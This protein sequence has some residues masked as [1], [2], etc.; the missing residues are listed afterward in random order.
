MSRANKLS[1]LRA[2]AL[3]QRIMRELLPEIERGEQKRTLVARDGFYRMA[4]LTERVTIALFVLSA[5]LAMFVFS[6]VSRHVVLLNRNLEQGVQER[7]AE[8]EMSLSSL[9]ESEDR[10]ALATRGANDGLWDWDLEEKRFY[11]SARWK[12]MLGLADEDIRESVHEWFTRVHL[13]DRDLLSMEIVAHLEGLTPHFEH[14][15]RIRHRDGEYRWVLARGLAIRGPGGEALRMA[16]SLTDVTNRRKAEEQLLYDAFHDVLTGLPNRA[17]FMD[18]LALAMKKA[19][20]KTQRNRQPVYAV[21]FLDVDRFKVVNDGLGHAIGDLLLSSIAQ[22][23]TECL[24][25]GDTVARIGGDEFAI[26]LDDLGDP[27][28]ARQIANRVQ[29]ALSRPFPL[30]GQEVFTSVSIGIAYGENRYRRPE[31]LLRDADTAM[32]RAKSQGKACHEVFDETMRARAVAVLEL[33]IHL[34][35][36]LEREELRVHYQPIVCLTTGALSG[37]E[38]LVRWQH[39]ER[40]LISP[41]EFI[42]AAEETGLIVPLE[43]WVIRQACRQ[44]KTWDGTNHGGEELSLSVNVSGRHFRDRSL[45]DEI[46]RALD[47]AGLEASRLKLEVTESVIMDNTIATREILGKLRDLGVELHM[48]D[49]GTGYS[50]MSYLRE[51]H[52]DALKIDRS[53]VS[54]MGPRGEH[55]QIVRTIVSLG[56]S[57]GLE[58]IAEGIETSEQ[59]EQLRTLK[60]QYGQG[61][62]FS[63]PLDGIAAQTV[64]LGTRE[65]VA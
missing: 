31:E 55:A 28:Q 46:A 47:E 51:F 5:V 54:Q 13:Q 58:V 45:P 8:L 63:K 36:A 35:H 56:H 24:R 4:R 23:L 29:E 65:W 3:G 30:A 34:R 22:R 14:E 39:P 1:S 18:R 49:F 43:R 40:G 59:L 10:Y 20:A 19:G 6:S 53:F 15:H 41:N 37:F 21:L 12:E 32:Y 2:D 52:I 64:L 50:S 11:C 62:L 44:L 17:L 27:D 48:D 38:A 61:F 57:L 42:E 9:R 60:C 16:G 33:D 7:T 26:L 25:P